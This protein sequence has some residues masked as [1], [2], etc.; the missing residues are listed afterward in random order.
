MS[1]TSPS[2]S[3]DGP[4]GS[5]SAGSPG[6]FNCPAGVLPASNPLVDGGTVSAGTPSQISNYRA[7]QY[8]A[9]DPSYVIDGVNYWWRA[10]YSPP[11]IPHNLTP[12]IPDNDAFLRGPFIRGPWSPTI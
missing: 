7:P 6:V 1:S 10:S 8:D 2:S 4:V 12:S 5:I 9:P 3:S 11:S